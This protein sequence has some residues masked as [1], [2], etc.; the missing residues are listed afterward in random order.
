[1]FTSWFGRKKQEKGGDLVLPANADFSFLGADMH[2]HFI[3]GIDDGS[4]SMDL[5]LAMLKDMADMGYK[6]IITTPHIMVD[7]YPNTNETIHIGFEALQKALVDNGIDISL[8]AAAEYYIDEYFMQKIEEG[9]LLTIWTKEV[10]VEF[11]TFS[12]PPMLKDVL[13]KMMT[14]GYRPVLAHPERYNFLHKDFDRFMEFK[15]RGCL[16]QLNMLSLIGY[17]GPSVKKVAD[18]LLEKGMYDY[19]GTDIHNEKHITAIKSILSNKLF[20][21]LANYPFLNKRLCF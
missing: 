18:Q 2:S 8:R 17:Y 13:F 5:S 7:F 9:N 15:D 10:L 12:E 4:V 19:C 11:S 21:T 1:M 14:S 6:T 20:S 3:P 16:L